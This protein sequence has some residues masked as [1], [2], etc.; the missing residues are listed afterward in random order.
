MRTITIE[1]NIYT[2]DELDEKA[3]G[4]VIQGYIEDYVHMYE[5]D[6]LDSTDEFNKKIIEA[7]DKS[8]EMHTP[9]FVGSYIMEV[10][11]KEI[12]ESAR[13]Q[14]YFADGGTYEDEMTE[15]IVGRITQ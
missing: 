1:E 3:Q 12:L 15:E 8:I 10:V 5:I 7:C 6:L 9:W 4:K 11:E 13:E 14:E 2:F